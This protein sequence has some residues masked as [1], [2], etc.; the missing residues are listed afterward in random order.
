[1]NFKQIVFQTKLYLMIIFVCFSTLFIVI[2]HT[3][4]DFLEN[5]IKISATISTVGGVDEYTFSTNIGDHIELRMA[6]Q[7]AYGSLSPHLKLF[8]PDGTLIDEDGS[9][10]GGAIVYTATESGTYT[11]LCSGTS[12]A[13]AG[14]YNLFYVRIP[15]ANEHGELTNG[16]VHAG[17]IEFGG[18]DTYTFSTNIDDHIE[19][20]MAVQEAYGSLSP[21]LKLFSP[22]GTLIDED[23]SQVGAIITYRTMNC[24]IY[25]VLCS[26]SSVATAGNYEL[27]FNLEV[28][29]LSDY[30][31]DNDGD[32]DGVDL[33]NFIDSFSESDLDE[34]A[35]AFGRQLC[36]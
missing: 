6:V 1:M 4:A 3:Y 7:E 34:F 5:D 33:K 12:V 15:G 23:G 8:S 11:V 27:K 21:H 26:G 36:F 28:G 18:L 14:D 32:L 2:N 16:N 17:T 20:R 31:F 10:V 24:G 30:D 25:T 22:D 35:T 19:L 13:T 29:N 9:Q